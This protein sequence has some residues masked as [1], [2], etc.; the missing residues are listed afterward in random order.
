M[1]AGRTAIDYAAAAAACGCRSRGRGGR[2]DR[3]RHGDSLRVI[4]PG[5]QSGP[6]HGSHSKSCQGPGCCLALADL[7][8]RAIVYNHLPERLLRVG[9]GT[10]AV[11]VNAATAAVHWPSMSSHEPSNSGSYAQA[12]APS[13][14]GALK[15]PLSAALIWTVAVIGRVSLCPIRNLSFQ[16][17]IRVGQTPGASPATAEG[18][19]GIPSRDSRRRF[20][21]KPQ[22]SA[23]RDL[24]QN[25]EETLP[26]VISGWISIR[27]ESC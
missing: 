19:L 17:L 8:K 22:P 25:C 1:K 5:G 21:G 12:Q 14:H 26:E 20:L 23:R 11:S 15:M 13:Q 7:K 9:L 4:L 16:R 24:S 27:F 18:T 10:A 3:D 6:G 2:D